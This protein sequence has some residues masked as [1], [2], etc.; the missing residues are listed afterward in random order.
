MVDI[1][2]SAHDAWVSFHHA[3]E[4]LKQNILVA[5]GETK[6]T[7]SAATKASIEKID[8]ALQTIKDH[9]PK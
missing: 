7:A 4:T 9:L 3:A 6:E 1:K 8:A 5:A 2:Q